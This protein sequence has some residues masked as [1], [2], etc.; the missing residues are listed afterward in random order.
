MSY[1]KLYLKKDMQKLRILGVLASISI[2]MCISLFIVQM[3]KKMGWQEVTGLDRVTIVNRS[4]HGFDVIWTTKK[5]EG[6]EQWVEVGNNQSSYPIHGKTEKIERV[7]SSTIVGLTAG[8]TYY[9]HIRSGS[10][11]YK[12]PSLL[13][14]RIILPHEVQEKPVTPAYGKVMEVNA[15]PY[16]NGLIMYEIDGYYPLAAFTKQ[17]GEWLIPLTGLIE[18]KNNT[19]ISLKNS[20]PVTITLFSYPEGSIRTT[21]SQTRPLRQVILAGKRI[22]LASQ[23][24]GTNASVLGVSSQTDK[25]GIEARIIYPKENAVIPGNTPLIRGTATPGKDIVVLIQGRKQYSYRTQA[26]EKG[27]WLVQSPVS[28]EFGRHFITVTIQNGVGATTVVRRNFSIIK[29]GEQV[30]GEATGSPTL[31]PT[32]VVPTYGNPTPTTVIFPTTTPIAIVP[33]RFI[34]TVT[35]PVTGGGVSSYLFGSLFL[36]VVGTGLVLAF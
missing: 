19:I 30:L 12:L 10:R 8:K 13:S 25:P 29:S 23:T 24:Q 14:N 36:I 32:V 9:F 6:S 20:T 31:A 35:P 15:Q 2:L 18:K 22:Q 21:V 7:Y 1:S 34:P 11:T 33:T 16:K 5:E 4:A 17:T 26:D 28:L 3:S 27:D